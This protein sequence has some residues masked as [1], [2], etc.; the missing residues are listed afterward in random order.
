MIR[1]PAPLASPPDSRSPL[2]GSSPQGTAR[3]G[4]GAHPQTRAFVCA[5]TCAYLP[6]R[7][8]RGPDRVRE[9]GTFHFNG[10]R[11]KILTRRS[12]PSCM[13]ALRSN[14]DGP[15]YSRWNLPRFRC[16]VPIALSRRRLLH[17]RS[18]RTRGE[19]QLRPRRPHSG[20]HHPQRS[21]LGRP[22]CRGEAALPIS[23]GARDHA[24]RSLFQM[25][26]AK[27]LQ[28]LGRHAD[29]EHGLRSRRCR[30]PINPARSSRPSPRTS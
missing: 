2:H 8:A 25:A 1:S 30:R 29:G 16:L 3:P 15:K 11:N 19:N 12:H 10:L 6:L 7:Q 14:R 17:R 27:N 23:A 18:E 13:V 26:V 28:G 24:G 22:R 4:L 5:P 9:R 20:S 21:H